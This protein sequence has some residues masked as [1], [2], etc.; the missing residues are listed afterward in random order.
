M[1]RRWHMVSYLASLP[2]DPLWGGGTMALAAWTTRPPVVAC[3]DGD[4]TGSAN[5]LQ[6]FLSKSPTRNGLAATLP[7]SGTRRKAVGSEAR[8]RIRSGS[9]GRLHFPPSAGTPPGWCPSFHTH[10]SSRRTGSGTVTTRYSLFSIAV[11]PAAARLVEAAPL[12]VSTRWQKA[13]ATLRLLAL[14]LVHL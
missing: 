1:A 11:R 13:A 8:P 4:K 6:G 3:L 12:S 9:L 5:P 14:L 2:T 10:S 7:D